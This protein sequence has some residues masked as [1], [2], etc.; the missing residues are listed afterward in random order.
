MYTVTYYKFGSRWFLDLPEYMEQG[1]NEEDLERVGAFHDFLEL[2]ALGEDTVVFH[3]DVEPFD[4]ADSAQL[5]G[6]SGGNT[7]GYYRITSFNDKPVDFEL[8]F[9]LLLYIKQPEL[10]KKVY[11]KQIDLPNNP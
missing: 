2:A 6:S 11:F 9:N 5:T 4:G 1:G 3:L 10:P 8:W 7:G